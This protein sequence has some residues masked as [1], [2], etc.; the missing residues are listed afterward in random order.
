MFKFRDGC[1]IANYESIKATIGL[2]Y[3]SDYVYASGY[4]GNTDTISFE[5]DKKFSAKNWLYLGGEATISHNT[6]DDIISISDL[7]SLRSESANFSSNLRPVFYLKTGNIVMT[8]NG[9]Y[10]NPYQLC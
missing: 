1:D 9:T 5:R 6:T 7:G 4:Y 8:G 10:D 2:L 3:P